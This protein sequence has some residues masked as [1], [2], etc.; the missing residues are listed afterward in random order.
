MKR[1]ALL[2][3]GAAALAQVRL[4]ALAQRPGRVYRVGLLLPM[5]GL[6]A[7]PYLA[8]IRQRLAA[9]GFVDGSNLQFETRLGNASTEA[10][11]LAALKLDAAFACTTA[12][13]APLHA[14]ARELPLVFAWVADPVAAGLVESY[15]RPGKPVTGVTNRFDELAQKRI[16]LL[17]E[18]RPAA[19]SAAL[20]AGI[21]DSGIRSALAKT[22]ATAER[23]RLELRPMEALGDWNGT[24]AKALAG[25]AELILVLTPFDVF[26][27]RY[28]AE[29]TV[30][31]S[32]ERRVPIVFSDA[33]S[34]ELGGLM[35]YG[36]DPLAEVRQAADLLAR[37]LKGE[38]P[39]DMPVEL[40]ARFQ[41][42]V[43]L[44]TA[45]AI[46]AEIPRSILLRADKVIE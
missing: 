31:F 3:A 16:E 35:S 10:R 23:L 11:E 42:A 2:A 29:E 38:K 27:M 6:T 20:I 7:E 5:A 13:A 45:R 9:H 14:A 12:L 4:R 1:R 24:L 26:G 34:V 28:T 43:N 25:G 15:A 33:P 19:T 37:V 40:A 8:A 18:L 39:A 36:G 32:M 30:R 44:S 41:L 46:G 17:R 22:Q 21:F